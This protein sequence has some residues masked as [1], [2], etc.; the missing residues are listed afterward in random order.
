MAKI[1]QTIGE[2]YDIIKEVGRGGM[3]K[4]YLAIDHNLNKR[5][6]IKEIER[7]PRD[8]NNFIAVNSALQ[9][10][11]MIKQF[12]HSGIVRIVDIIDNGNVIYIIEDYIDGEPLSAKLESSGAQ[13][14]EK[15]I[16]WAIQICDTLEYL[17]TRKDPVIYRDM[18]PA[19]I[20]LNSDGNIRLIDFGIA[21]KSSETGKKH[22]NKK[23]VNLGTKGYAPPEQIKGERQDARTDIYALGVTMYSLVTGQI[24]GRES[25][26]VKP[27]RY[28]N[29]QLSS[30]LE[31]IIEK[32]MQLDPDKRYQ[33]CAELMYALQHY[34]EYSIAY[35]ARQKKKLNF[36][37][38]AVSAACFFLCLGILGVVMRNVT[39]S[40]D[41]T[42]NILQAEKTTNEEEKIQ[43]YSNAVNVDPYAMEAYLGMVEAFKDD[44]VFTTEESIT[45]EKI[46]NENLSGL[47]NQRGYGNL[48]FEIG[49]LYWY[50]YDYGKTEGGDNQVTRMKSSVQW[51]EDAVE[52]GGENSEFYHQ[53]VV[54]RDIGRFNQ[55]ITLRVEE[56]SDSGL[57]AP[58]WTNIQDLVEMV[59]NDT[60]E[61]EIVELEVYKL[62][63][64]SMETYARKFKAE[65]VEQTAMN[66]LY[67][68]VKNEVENIQ[69]T[70]DKTASLKQEIADRF[71]SAAAAIENAF[72]E[73]V[74]AE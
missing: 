67:D 51:F 23:K 37:I 59:T 54:Y 34:D 50:Y 18:K 24:P 36:F 22:P 33:S 7:R 3:S 9:E 69:T 45:F 10:A 21:Q 2:K 25:Y 6:A 47:R 56:A 15:V 27:I 38:A 61:S 62:A 16:Q 72:R 14:Q 71:D 28:W 11:D 43:F 63:M 29:P 65:G 26:Q 40:A 74:S 1:G 5:W 8:K 31:V 57:Y 52:Y 73:Q 19:N 30:G 41:Y 70:S 46:I 42:Q 20:M 60:D 49:K 64:F 35:H 44:A 17:H 32:C 53:A 13:P 39:N 4:V 58:Y 66:E 68:L 55:D 12:D 48:A